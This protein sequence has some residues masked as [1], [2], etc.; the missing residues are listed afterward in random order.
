MSEKNK[1]NRFLESPVLY[2]FSNMWKFSTG[3]KKNVIIFTFMYIMSNFVRAIE[4]LILAL[5]INTIQVEGVNS[6]SIS[7]LFLILLLFLVANLFFWSVHGPARVIEQKNA[8]IVR[9]NYRKYLVDGVLSLSSHWHINNQTGDTIDKV[10]KASTALYNFST[11]TFAIIGSLIGLVTSYFALVYF[12]IHA[13]YIVFIGMA[14]VFIYIIRVDKVLDKQ[15]RELNLMENK[16]SAKIYDSISNVSTVIILRIEKLILNDIMKKIWQP[17]SLEKNNIKKNEIKWFFVSFTNTIIMV[18]ILG[19]FIYS[20]YVSGEVILIGT[21]S[22]LFMY[23]TRVSDIFFNLTWRYGMIVRQFSNLKNVEPITDEFKEKISGNSIKFGKTWKNLSIKKLNFVYGE[24]KNVGNKTLNNVSF[25]ISRGERVAIIGESGSGKTTFMKL[26]RSLYESNSV[27]IDIDGKTV[28]NGF[29]EISSSIM[30]IPQEPEIFTST[31]RDNITVG[32]SHKLSYIKKFTD[33]ACFTKVAEKLPKKWDSSVVEKGVNLSGG[34]KQRLAL[35]RALMAADDKE[36]LLMDEST[37]SVDPTNEVK[38][39]KNVFKSFK[40]KTIIASIHKLNLLHLFDR[41]YIFDN[42]K[43]VGCGTFKELMSNSK[44]FQKIWT[45][46]E[47][48]LK[49]NYD[50]K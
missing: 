26:F 12:N 41:I 5:L 3:N 25:N 8:F 22:A 4:P 1:K 49:I 47:N 17:F 2:L 33:L 50:N 16:I 32:I 10:S 9:V 18:L 29:D 24:N 36:I 21:V 15:Y 7:K 28:K 14:V 31:I 27:S 6:D 34:E 13:S 19:S 46:Y 39:Y 40:D 44:K 20:N 30:L 43:V 37:S 48:S 11:D 23:V 42:G 35:A 38:I 45:K